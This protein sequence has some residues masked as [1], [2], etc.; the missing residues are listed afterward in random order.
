MSEIIDQP[1]ENSAE[2]PVVTPIPACQACG[3]QD[4]TLRLVAYPYVV[5]LLIVSQ[6]GAFSGIWCSK[7]RTWNLLKASVLTST[8]GWLGIPHGIINTP[9]S[10]SKL[11]QGG[12]QPK[13]AN[14][15]ILQALAEEQ[16][17]RADTAGSVRCLEEA[18]RFGDNPEICK[19]LNEVRPYF[20]SQEEPVGWTRVGLSFIGVLCLCILVGAIV[21]LIDYSIG[22]ILGNTLGRE[23]PFLVVI[24]SWLPLVAS[25]FV[26]ALA[27]KRLVERV[28]V[29]VHCKSLGLAIPFAVI[30]ALL[31]TYGI[32]Q[33]HIIFTGILS[34]LA[35]E[36]KSV[37][38]LV[39]A[40]LITFLAGGF[41][42]VAWEASHEPTWAIFLTVILIATAFYI[43]GNI[44]SARETVAWQKRIK[45]G[46]H[47]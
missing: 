1:A 40:W 37:F 25:A 47:L 8:L 18:L 32:F 28:L 33:G 14:V 23:M 24:L 26:G 31:V 10:L 41:V 22:Y 3:R 13:D 5:S 19:R 46:F 29:K 34:T 38:E 42:E 43:Y 20:G 12:I 45:P 44:R 21:G 35:G 11:A 27:G 16:L 39:A 30:A 36:F 4:E 2:K 9:I 6:R 15:R 17:R 7:H